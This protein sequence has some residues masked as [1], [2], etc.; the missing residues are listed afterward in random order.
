MKRRLDD[1]F[2]IF[3]HDIFFRAGSLFELAVSKS[4]YQRGRKKVLRSRDCNIPKASEIHFL[5]PNICI[6]AI[7]PILIKHKCIGMTDESSKAVIDKVPSDGKAQS[8]SDQGNDGDPFLPWIVGCLPWMV[9][10]T[11]LH[12]SRTKVSLVLLL[13]MDVN[14]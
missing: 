11:L 4:T 7:A 12:P 1:E 9:N 2:A 8:K 5:G 6:E 13:V 3:D 14:G 10:L